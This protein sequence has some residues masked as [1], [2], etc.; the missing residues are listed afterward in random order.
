MHAALPD[1]IVRSLADGVLV[2][3]RDGRIVTLNP[4]A[5]RLLDLQGQTVLGQP[6]SAVFVPN[7]DLDDLV[8]AVLD[9]IYQ[10]DVTHNR[11]LRLARP[12]AKTQVLA[13]TTSLLADDDGN[14][15]GVV[16]LLNDITEVD[17]LRTREQRL[18]SELTAAYRDLEA[19]NAELTA[20]TRRI[21][22]ARAMA[23]GF[24]LLL[25]V[26]L[27]VMVWNQGGAPA[28]PEAMVSSAAESATLTLEPRV[29]RVSL[30][31]LGALEPLAVVNLV[32]ALDGTVAE[33]T[34]EYGEAVSA[35]D[36][37]FVIARE[38]AEVKYRE[39][40]AVYLGAL[41][42]VERLRAW[43][44]S[45][46]IQRA[47][48]GV[49][50]AEANLKTLERKEQETRRLLELGIV[51]SSELDTLS[52][53]L[54]SARMELTQTLEELHGTQAQG[55]EEK[56]TV[57][58]LKLDNALYSMREWEDKLAKTTVA[59]PVDGVVMAP[60]ASQ[61]GARSELLD[62]GSAVKEGVAV[63]AI[64]DLTGLSVQVTVDELEVSLLQPG[65][66]ALV[67]GEA[68]PG[69]RL[70]GEV[71]R[72]SAQAK[73][74]QG[75]AAPTFE[76]YVHVQDLSP[77]ERARIRVGMSAQVEVILEEEPAALM[78]PL[79]AVIA[80][81]TGPRVRVREQGSLR[82]VPVT[83]GFTNLDSVRV[84]EGLVPGMEIVVAP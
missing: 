67:T 68:F 29:N 27:G 33:R 57:A 21:A 28:I 9:A 78:I 63:L 2:I 46:E 51:P 52:D 34:F 38:P 10:D 30:T 24:V 15:L 42:E 80:D 16:V 39:A 61:D 59:A 26:S 14:R 55:A 53:Q 58:Q 5:E 79:G 49:T 12:D 17:A 35:G 70:Q 54:L 4:A 47:R 32:A 64:G 66:P 81:P 83:L 8:Q 6:F 77:A 19:R 1:W 31:L 65:Q 22:L 45:A 60:T 43:D 48:R 69:L 50:R 41:E 75:K 13:L 18:N 74:T 25:F 73:L 3:G 23:T 84:L 37:L 44:D 72:V 40:R 11:L 62:I 71:A 56:L 76:V 36:A 82:E 7:V 20:L